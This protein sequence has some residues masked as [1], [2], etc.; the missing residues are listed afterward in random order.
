MENNPALYR[1]LDNQMEDEESM[2]MTEDGDGELT[3]T[4][5]VRDMCY[6]LL[7]LYSD[8]SHR[9]ERVLAPTTHSAYQL[10][11]RLR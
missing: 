5:V 9:M 7:K 3:K 8:R 11:Y 10:D 4:Y 2:M 6:H 1:D